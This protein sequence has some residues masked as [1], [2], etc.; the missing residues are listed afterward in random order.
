MIH[1][2]SASPSVTINFGKT[3]SKPSHSI[4][5]FLA[6][7][8]IAVV[9][10]LLV[11]VTGFTRMVIVLGLTRN[12]MG[13]TMPP[14][15]VL[16]GVALF[17][18]LF[19]MAPTLTQMNNVG[20]QP[21]LHGKASFSQAVDAAEKPLDSWLLVQTRT[22]DLA[23]LESARGEHPVKPTK[24][25]LTTVIP[26]FLL[27]Q[28]ESA[29]VIGFVI[30]VPFLIIDLL[31]SST[32]MSMGMVMLPPTLISM[33]FKILLFVVVDGWSLIAHALIVSPH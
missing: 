3:L 22:N 17:L 14:N 1:L 25:P 6:L 13:L 15:Q 29:F 7:A 28:L 19:V 12:A 4:V 33:P 24:A 8:L 18:S 20:L 21:Y 32:L 10:Y 5:I 27:S 26:A 16:T 2:L 9:P 30:F 23:M 31:V 11:M